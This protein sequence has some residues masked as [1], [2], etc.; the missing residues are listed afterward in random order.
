MSRRILLAAT[1]LA[2]SLNSTVLCA[3]VQ[4]PSRHDSRS[5]TGVSYRGGGFSF[6]EEDLLVGDEAT[7]LRL[8]RSYNSATDAL[9]DPYL[10]AV[11][12]THS[13]NIYVSAQPLP[14]NPDDTPPPNYR[15]RCVYNVVGG[16]GAVGFVYGG[17]INPQQTGC[18]GA[19][20]GPYLPITP[21]GDTLEYISG[22]SPYYQYIGADGAIIN[23]TP[24]ASGRALNW[25]KPDGTVLS[26]TYVSGQLKS[27]FSNRGWGLLFESATKICA[28][29]LSKTYVGT[30]SA[31][32]ADAQTVTYTYANGSYVSSWKL[33]TSATRSGSTRT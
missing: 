26:F 11:G 24:G 5:P 1:I 27:V 30:T 23:F 7:G 25:T 28:V 15:G 9:S 22:T 29:N 16:G 3:Q 4:T 19:Q 13:M 14:E 17:T 20:A 6:E 18:G 2:G 31:C 8:V 10:A 21:S 12:W 33:M 32:P